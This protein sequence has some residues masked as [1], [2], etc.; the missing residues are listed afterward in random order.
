LPTDAGLRPGGR[1]AKPTLQECLIDPRAEYSIV[2]R[3]ARL[4]ELW[5]QNCALGTQ[6]ASRCQTRILI[7]IMTA[8]LR[9][10][11]PPQGTTTSD[12]IRGSHFFGAFLSGFLFAAGQ[13][14]IG[15]VAADRSRQ[16][17]TTRSRKK[18]RA[19][20][21]G[22][23][24]RLGLWTNPK[25]DSPLSAPGADRFWTEGDEGNKGQKPSVDWR[26]GWIIHRKGINALL[27][28]FHRQVDRVVL[29]PRIMRLQHVK[30]LSKSTYIDRHI[31]AVCADYSAATP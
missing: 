10:S 8:N 28:A 6:A 18:R 15:D 30:P 29:P 23:Q 26:E 11:G 24:F 22:V 5:A 12:Q 27:A 25:M 1:W 17:D 21:A 3:C 16:P 4:R 31:L 19:R 13:C 20:R 14:R 9:V 2:A 7:L